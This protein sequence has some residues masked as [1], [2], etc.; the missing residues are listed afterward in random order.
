MNKT[1][2][3]LILLKQEQMKDTKCGRGVIVC[4]LVNGRVECTTLKYGYP[5]C[6]MCPKQHLNLMKDV[7]ILG[8]GGGMLERD[9][10]SL[11]II[12]REGA[13]L[14]FLSQA[15]TKIYKCLDPN[16]G[17]AGQVMT[18]HIEKGAY[19]ALLPEPVTCFE[20]SRYIQHQSFHLEK[21]A[22]LL[23]LDWMTSGRSSR[24][25]SWDFHRYISENL[26]YENGELLLRDPW[27]L[28]NNQKD[29]QPN[30]LCQK[31]AGFHC[32]ANLI[33]IGEEVKSLI[34]HLTF[35][36]NSEKISK[37]K[38]DQAGEHIIWSVSC[39]RPDFLILR[40]AAK[41]TILMRSF[42]KFHFKHLSGKEAAGFSRI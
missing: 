15:S 38:V 4:E 36:S 25:E 17:G 21:G 31:M 2:K 29:L 3:E 23:L 42:L 24:G 32:I 33:M 7:Y 41:D 20:N 14:T 18:C 35:F 37:R 6:L 30:S 9:Q 1:C 22:S 5:L 39:L 34:S 10:I 13:T 40:A 16:V 8:F 11:S 12:I 26:I 27:L 28:E 19:F